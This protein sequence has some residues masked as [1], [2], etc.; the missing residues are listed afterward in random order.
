M[1]WNLLPLLALAIAVGK[2]SRP[3]QLLGAGT[4]LASVSILAA[5]DA[6]FSPSNLGDL[7][8]YLI[9]VY[10]ILVIVPMGFAAGSLVGVARDKLA[11]RRNT[12]SAA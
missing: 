11:Q 12:E 3:A 6:A 2:A 7:A 9:P 10:G 1:V 5:V 8:L 4:F